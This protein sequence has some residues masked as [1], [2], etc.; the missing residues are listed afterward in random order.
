MQAA[1]IR[2]AIDT[3]RT[4]VEA[5]T[6]TGARRLWQL[7]IGAGRPGTVWRGHPPTALELEVAI[8]AVEDAL[9]PLVRELPAG[10]PLSTS[11]PFARELRAWLQAGPELPLEDVERAFDEM[12]AVA[13][14]RSASASTLPQDA[15]FDGWLL[16]LREFMHHGGFARLSIEED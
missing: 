6:P 10:L 14:G 15:A 11:D 9:M 16:V 2:L 8:A 13:Q 3:D 7:P 4:C 5:P 12:A 1:A